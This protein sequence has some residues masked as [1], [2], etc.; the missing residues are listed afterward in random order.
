V[1]EISRRGFLRV[2]GGAAVA[3]AAGVPFAAAARTPPR[4]RR[5]YAIVGT[6]VRGSSMWGSSVLARHGDAVELVGLC[7]VNRKRADVVK[8]RL[9][10]EAPIFTDLD[11]MLAAVRPELLAVT[12]VDST[13]ADCIVRGLSSGADVITEKPMVTDEAQCQRVLD[14]AQATDRRLMVGFNYRFAR[15]HRQIKELL[16]SGAIG[17]V[18]SVDFHWYLDVHHGADY[19]RR[20][21]RLRSRSGSL[22]V[23]KAT[24]HFDLVNWWLDAAPVEVAA[25]AD[26]K[27]YGRN[28]PFR[29]GQCRGCPH[30]ADCRFFWDITKDRGLMQLYVDCESE[31]GYRRDGCVFRDDIDSFDTM[32]LSV[33]YS[34]GVQMS[35]SL[36]AAMPFEGYR[37]AFNGTLGRLEVRDH[38]RQP[39]QPEAPTEIWLTRSFGQRESIAVET[40]TGGHG[41]G[42]ELLLAQVFGAASAA[43]EVPA[44]LRLPTVRDGALSCLT[45]IAARRSSDERRV[46]RIDELVRGL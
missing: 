35:Y 23:H 19:F 26:L 39:W 16:L 45:G 14:A 21:H 15:K 28:G 44:W 34:N 8:G 22:L 46:V 7:D 27:V 6:G 3:S 9:K 33:R 32:N 12:T 2:A 1:D 43:P 38:E 4:A 31:D 20:W 41:G 5:R 30:A 10:T 42:D 37:L 24:H 18:T 11:A 13:H 25:F 40:V 17:T 36:N 29:H